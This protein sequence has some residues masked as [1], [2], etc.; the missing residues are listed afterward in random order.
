VAKPPPAT[1]IAAVRIFPSVGLAGAV[2]VFAKA[3]WRK[4][5]GGCP[6]TVLPGNARIAEAKMGSAINRMTF[7]NHEK[8][9][10]LKVANLDSS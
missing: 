3:A 1:V 5:Y 4:T 2:S 8:I 6:A 10:I 7:A 9:I